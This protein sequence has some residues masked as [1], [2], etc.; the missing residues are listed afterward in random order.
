MNSCLKT[1]AWK[2]HFNTVAHRQQKTRLQAISFKRNSTNPWV[3]TAPAVH[4][5]Q[6][7]SLQ[8][9]YYRYYLK[10]IGLKPL[11]T[12]HN[13]STRVHINTTHVFRYHI[14][15]SWDDSMLLW[16]MHVN[17]VWNLQLATP[18][19]IRNHF[20]YGSGFDVSITIAQIRLIQTFCS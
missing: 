15:C 10:R 2:Q 11:A 19:Q 5:L 12:D 20:L 4:F 17:A 18:D 7:T 8:R 16:M 14:P 13:L 1:S 6:L 3:N 9:S